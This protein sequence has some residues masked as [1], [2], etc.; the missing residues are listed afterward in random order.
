[1]QTYSSARKTLSASEVPCLLYLSFLLSTQQKGKNLYTVHKVTLSGLFSHR[2][3]KGKMLRRIPTACLL[4]DPVFAVRT[5]CCPLLILKPPDM[6]TQCMNPTAHKRPMRPST[7]TTCL[8]P[9]SL[10]FSTTEEGQEM[11]F[12]HSLNTESSYSELGAPQYKAASSLSPSHSQVT[13][14]G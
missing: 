13:S 14:W 6:V 12:T 3:T 2:G 4:L 7:L 9:L 10:S 11:I 8:V 1:M 5:G